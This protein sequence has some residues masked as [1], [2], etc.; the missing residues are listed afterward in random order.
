M[1]GIR[2]RWPIL[3]VSLAG[4]ALIGALLGWYFLGSSPAAADPGA[5]SDRTNLLLLGRSTEEGGE[6][7][8][9]LVA[10]LRASSDAV[11]IAVPADLTIKRAGGSL[12]LLRDLDASEGEAAVATAVSETLGVEIDGVLAWDDEGLIRIVDEVGGLPVTIDVDVTYA[13]AAGEA[14]EI[15]AGEQTLGGREA[16]AYLRGASSE[17]VLDRQARLVGA[18]IDRGLVGEDARSVR[19]L[20]RELDSSIETGLSL[21][22][23]ER[24]ALALQSI[25][26]EAVRVVGLPSDVAVV[27]GENSAR[28]KAVETERLVATFVRGLELLTPSEV[29]VAVFNGNGVR[30][31]ASETAEYLRARG[32]QV[33]RIANADSFDYP[34]SYIVVLTEEAKAWVLRDALPISVSIVFPDAFEDH[35]EALASL[36]PFGTDLML[37]AGAGMELD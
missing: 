17:S 15:R 9:V 27:D 3:A 14:I 1:R 21:S 4:L 16:L 35:Y 13:P 36:V 22:A 33:T 29:Q 19:Q 7:R 24:A 34:T 2:I 28:L 30:L 26:G 6:L 32:F 5:S 11:F 31:M 8:D 37:I 20:V 23:L 10:S 25:D 18:W 12:D